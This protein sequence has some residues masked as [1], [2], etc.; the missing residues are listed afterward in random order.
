MDPRRSSPDCFI[1]AC[2]F[3]FPGRRLL[4]PSSWSCSSI[5]SPNLTAPRS[6][7]WAGRNDFHS[8]SP[9]FLSALTHLFDSWQNL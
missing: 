6:T 4:M 1:N 5:M 7:D 8:P 2:V 9:C 3:L